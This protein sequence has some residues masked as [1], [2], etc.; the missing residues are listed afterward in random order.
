MKIG[1]IGAGNVGGNLGIRLA[2]H[3]YPVRFGV[4]P[5]ADV[6]E[7][8]DACEGRA[9]ATSIADAAAWADVLFLAVPHA[10]AVNAAREA[11]PLA[12]KV[13]VD[14]TNP[15]SWSADGPT[16]APMPEG[17]TA[18]ALTRALPQA[19]V[20]KGFNT[21]GAEFHLDPALAGT[22]VDVYLA[23]DDAGAK[24]LV[25]GIASRAGFTPVDSGPL[26]NAALLE[27]LAVL[28]IHL[29]VKGGQGRH[30]A[31]KLLKRG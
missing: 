23:G 4:R 17:S 28:W 21:F 2:R 7:T 15:V 16:L 20:V 8:L 18:A 1:I 3:G 10:A 11:G 22:S 13:L 6:K 14:C 29:A 31:F 9:E 19:R 12:G 27:N 30:V 26:R 5:G 24:Q 25:G